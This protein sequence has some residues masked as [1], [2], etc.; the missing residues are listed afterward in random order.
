MDEV[1]PPSPSITMVIA[2][3]SLVTTVSM[4]DFSIGRILRPFLIHVQYT[5]YDDTMD[6]IILRTLDRKRPRI[7]ESSA[8]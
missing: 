2:R 5:I 6:F 8:S 3:A 1:G 4:I 7:V